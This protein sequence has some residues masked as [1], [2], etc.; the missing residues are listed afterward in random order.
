MTELPFMTVP[1]VAEILGVS[2]PRAYQLAAEGSFPSLRLSSR[3]IR[4]PR[5]A[6]ETWLTTQAE[7]ALASVVPAKEVTPRRSSSS[8]AR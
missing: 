3:R 5:A 8:T 4:I 1:Q 6:F 7:I 2:V